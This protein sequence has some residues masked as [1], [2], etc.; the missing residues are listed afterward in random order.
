MAAAGGPPER[1]GPTRPSASTPRSGRRGD[2]AGAADL[3]E[4]PVGDL[5]VEQPAAD[6]AGISQGQQDGAARLAVVS[7]PH[8]GAARAARDLAAGRG[9]AR[10]RSSGRRSRPCRPPAPAAARRRPPRRPR[11]C[12]P[13]G[14]SLG[15]GGSG[16][17]DGR[18]SSRRCDRIAVDGPL[19][20]DAVRRSRR[21]A[22]EDAGGELGVVDDAPGRVAAGTA[23]R[24]IRQRRSPSNSSPTEAPRPVRRPRPAPR[25]SSPRSSGA[26]QSSASTTGA[27]C[28]V[29]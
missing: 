11:R 4:L 21:R 8:E 17:G 7:Q 28:G 13:V 2:R 24:P 10:R 14:R 20:R 18:A 23:V 27:G 26:T 6:A 9:V 5:G 29:P 1:S 25:R 16:G 22:T 12:R 15:G 3:A 19:R